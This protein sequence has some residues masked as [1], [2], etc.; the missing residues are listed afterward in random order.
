MH[1]LDVPQ[2]NSRNEERGVVDGDSSKPLSIPLF[3]YRSQSDSCPAQGL[4]FL[5][6]QHV[7]E[8]QSRGIWIGAQ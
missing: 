5:S 4:I 1:T 3:Q 8:K 7:Q 6:Y 2:D